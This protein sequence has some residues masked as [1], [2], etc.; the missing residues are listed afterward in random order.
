L[1]KLGLFFLFV[2]L[3][4]FTKAQNKTIDSLKILLKTE[5]KDTSRVQLI[6]QLSYQFENSN[7]DTALLLAQ[8]GL[9]LSKKNRFTA[10][11]IECLNMTGLI[12]IT[13][14]NY[15]KA[16]EYLLES[17]KKSEAIQ[18]ESSITTELS[19][20]GIVYSA[21]GDYRQDIRYNLMALPIDK[22]L[23]HTRNIAIMQLNLGDSYEKLNILDSAIYF[24]S[25]SYALSLQ[26]KYIDLTGVALNNFGNIY[27][28]LG[29]PDTALK[30]YRSDFPYL[31]DANDEDDFCETYLGMSKI[32]QS[33][34]K[35]DSCLYYAK[36]CL[37][38][39]KKAGFTDEVMESCKFLTQYYQ[40]AHNIDSAF[41]YQSAGI[42]ARDS[43]FSQEKAR[44]MQTLRFDEAVR[45]QQIEEAKQEAHTQLI[46][47]VLFGGLF[48]L[49]VAAIILYRN[50]RQKQKAN[51]ILED[52]K[53]KL[54]STLK[55]LR[56]TQAQL[57]H[58]EKMASLGQL[59]AG[60]AHE[61]QN[62]L[63]FVN[64][65]SELSNELINEMV[66][67]VDKGNT[68]QV[69]EIANDIKQNLEKINHHGK[70]ADA[71]VKGMLQHS[72][73]SKNAKDPTDINALADEYLRLS[74]HGLRA[75]DKEFN[76]LINTEFD[77]SI[78][79]INI[80][81]EDIGRVLL[82]LYNNAFYAVGEKKKSEGAGYEP[83]VSISTN[84]MD[85]MVFITVKDNGNGIPQNV[86]DKIFHPF[87]TTKPPGQGTG[88]GLSLSYDIVKAHN[89]EIK[90][91][92][93]EGE[94]TEF[95]VRLPA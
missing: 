43:L 79:K 75:K 39:A 34:G 23:N 44:E 60:I 53:Q 40:S 54:E 87:F 84:K 29:K 12:F 30:Y 81:P 83:A 11:E 15:P 21:Q 19:N 78:G 85:N 57:I 22:S 73:S 93:T 52:Q 24:T 59:T 46:L 76:A 41:V 32:F 72:R 61:I 47:N 71:I 26:S 45:Q 55:E 16:L 20:I 49:I 65:F 17:L 28:K 90:V 68:L 6:V 50:N 89:G 94:F 33:A 66:E 91:N 31:K 92:R 10:G 62:P 77:N 9:L 1:K 51:S 25:Q 36:L 64:N 88:L 86:V 35:K 8:Q 18:D 56:T 63:N 69:K 2:M 67:E 37:S 42:A 13:T 58:A 38:I 74:Y 70:R 14:G 27:S 80:V 4:A 5:K 82:N 3:Y 95:V 7:P 48:T